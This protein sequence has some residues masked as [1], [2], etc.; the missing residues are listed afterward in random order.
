M[1]DPN[2]LLQL[3][4]AWKHQV[5]Q[6]DV[7]VEDLCEQYPEFA[8]AIRKH[9]AALETD[10]VTGS[11]AATPGP[12]QDR[13]DSQA[14][15]CDPGHG[16]TPIIKLGKGAYGEVWKAV[17]ASDFPVALKF[18][19]LEDGS[20]CDE[21]RALTLLKKIRH[22]HLTAYH[23]AWQVGNWL[24]VDM[25][26]ADGSLWDH[27]CALRDKGQIGL[28]VEALLKYMEEAAEAID[29]LNEPHHQFD[30]GDGK[31]LRS[32]QHRDIKPHNL[33][34]LNDSIKVGDFGLA[35]AMQNSVSFASRGMAGTPAYA[36][37]EVWKGQT[38]RWSDQYA[39]AIVYYQMRS[40]K[41]P[42]SGNQ[43]Q[44]MYGHL[45][46]EPN[47][48]AVGPEERE[49]L[50]RALR[51]EPG[52]RWPN[53]KALVK[54]L[55]G[56]AVAAQTQRRAASALASQ[57][58]KAKPK[59]ERDLRTL[60]AGL[61][62]KGRADADAAVAEPPVE[63]DWH[64]KK[65]KKKTPTRRW[66]RI[67][68]AAAAFLVVAGLATW[69]VFELIGASENK[70]KPA[71]P[72]IVVPEPKPEPPPAP[73]PRAVNVVALAAVTMAVVAELNDRCQPA[74][75]VA[76][77]VRLGPAPDPKNAKP[78][79]DRKA[80]AIS[81][82]TLANALID[83]GDLGLALPLYNE[84]LEFDA[85]STA[86]F[87]GRAKVRLAL[88][89]FPKALA[90]A[91]A[92]VKLEPEEAA[93]FAMRGD[94]YLALEDYSPA[95]ADFHEAKAL[96]P[97]QAKH[98]EKLAR[99]YRYRAD[100]YSGLGRLKE[101]LVDFSQAINIAPRDA[102]H[103]WARGM[104]FYQQKEHGLAIEDFDMAI[105]ILPDDPRLHNYRGLIYMRLKDYDKAIANYSEAIRLNPNVVAFRE[106]GAEA[107]AARGKL[108]ES[109][110][111]YTEAIKLASRANYYRARGELHVKQKDDPKA[112]PDFDKAIELEPDDPQP[113]NARGEIYYRM[114]EY[115][116]AVRDHSKAI[117]L[118]P[119]EAAYWWNRAGAYK[120]LGSDDN[121][122][123]AVEDYSQAIR[124]AP[125]VEHL[126][127]RGETYV[128]L[129]R[130]DLA[131]VDFEIAI[132]V[133]PDY[134]R[135]YASRG[136]IYYRMQDYKKAVR[137]HSKAIGLDP[138][139]A[140]YWGNRASAHL[141]LRSFNK[142]VDDYSEAINLNPREVTYWGNRARA[143]LALH[144]FK[145][146]VADYTAA[147]KLNGKEA[148]YWGN[149]ARA[150]EELDNIKE[151]VKDYTEAIS[152]APGDVNWLEKR[153]DLYFGQEEY[154]LALKDF[155]KVIKIAP[156]SHAHNIRGLIF[157]D[158]MNDFDEDFDEAIASFTKALKLEENVAFLKNRS[159]A[160]RLKK[161]KEEMARALAD[162]DRA[163][164]LNK[165]DPELHNIRGGICRAMKYH[166]K[167]I[168]SYDKAIALNKTNAQY[169]ANRGVAYQEQ[170]DPKAA[171]ENIDKAIEL[172]GKDPR[173]HDLRGLFLYQQRDF[174]RAI[175][176][177]QRAIG[178]N[179][180]VADYHDHL[181]DAYEKR[182][183]EGDKIRAAGERT[184]ANTAR[185]YLKKATPKGKAP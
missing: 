52:Q 162:I 148:A 177:F 171:L 172:A 181:A 24:L 27:F 138:K 59:P 66:L 57:A 58:P 120:A 135:P 84:A 70:E 6:G 25:E 28:P 134:A 2:A 9:L 94:V 76:I 71:D 115:K 170:K 131:L 8:S 126:Q 39:L 184:A 109:V 91:D 99:A 153:G 33:L 19:R 142:A 23:A 43:L 41:L 136:E 67:A 17:N 133:A 111:D 102:D 151:A 88:R 68:L 69:G 121:D 108:K 182:G 13:A 155:D 12:G 46:K 164:E 110:D 174:D 167:A 63:K 116:K 48:E 176:S 178:L 83:K 73:K 82:V 158:H 60:S 11:A 180:N 21:L 107:Y 18:I 150:Y 77:P 137:D 56:A 128:E 87:R 185:Q 92:A 96:Q 163:I 145:E 45:Q 37:P 22:C 118:N 165:Q 61:P 152:L 173:F 101:A 127:A 114:E 168:A 104:F 100:L 93:N 159:I 30:E 103:W 31:P 144:R 86:A 78:G 42:F 156:N 44:Q 79:A 160:F 26:L 4:D 15:P 55:A 38:S 95:I 98:H 146:A 105:E 53:C 123:K 139:E 35:K 74:Q 20:V 154:K 149:R 32:I 169:W 81:A 161:G 5:R 49:V 7:S 36:A 51:K 89:D 143:H 34:L 130:D 14:P 122:N 54:A 29:F 64:N 125:R 65:P 106:N 183:I 124:R 80:Q 119:N 90:D 132:D 141:A 85:L 75:P 40:G 97:E 157:L 117:G 16:Y 147:I 72:V 140:A 129:K 112:L 62:K 50:A 47:L 10:S 3:I 1:P 179:T 175:A 113:H 166:D